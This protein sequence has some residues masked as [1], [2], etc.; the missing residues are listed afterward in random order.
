MKIKK[1]SFLAGAILLGLGL[2]ATTFA[3][4]STTDEIINKL[5]EQIRLLV[6][7]LEDLRKAQGQI[8]ST[9]QSISETLKLAGSLGEGSKGD[10]VR[11]L[12]AALAADSDIYPEGLISGFYGK[13]T[14]LAVKRFQKKYGLDQVGRV[15]PKTLA[16]LNEF[17]ND[18]NIIKEKEDDEKKGD[19]QKEGRG[20]ICVIVPPGH[21]IAPG[22]LRKHDDE[23]PTVPACQIIPPGIAKKLGMGTTTPPTSDIVPPV[24]SGLNAVNIK[25]T[26]V[27]V[28]WMTNEPAKGVLYFGT[29]S[30]IT[31]SNSSSVRTDER[32]TSFGFTLNN[33]A[34]ST[35]YYY[36]VTAV[37]KAGNVATSSQQSFTTSAAPDTVAPVISLVSTNNIT[38]SGVSVVWTTNENANSKVYY[39][40]SSPVNLLTAATVSDSSYSTTHSVALSNLSASTNYFFV[41]SS[42]DTAGN[43]ATGTEQAFSTQAP[44]DITAP[45]ISSISASGV[46]STSTT[47]SWMTNESATSRV[48]YGTST[49]LSLASAMTVSNTTLTLDHSVGLTDLVASTTYHY[50]VGS[51]DAAQNQATSSEQ[52]FMTF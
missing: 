38:T 50:V 12:Q 4:G 40:T 34:T 42:S 39:S 49:P 48:Y 30:P 46:T 22:W 18:N 6:A 9:A 21:L 11:I 13:L 15:G 36:F 32:A 25:M 19:E 16:K 47:I 20:R 52:S 14:A 5:Q 35:N 26:S 51:S 45:I 1:L 27:S 7:Q 10:Q 24:I 29:S 43:T 31:I 8:A 2:S 23:K 44:A 37:D 33:L 17:L 28:V 41:V 3:A